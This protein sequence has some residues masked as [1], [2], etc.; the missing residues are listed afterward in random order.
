MFGSSTIIRKVVLS[1]AHV[2][3][4]HLCACVLCGGV[5]ACLGLPDDGRRPKHVGAIFV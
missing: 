2:I 4:D 1:L 5:A 3:G